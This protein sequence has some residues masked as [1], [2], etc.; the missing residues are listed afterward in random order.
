[1][2]APSQLWDEIRAHF[3]QGNG[4]NPTYLKAQM[5]NRRLQASENVDTFVQD[6]ERRRRLL[7][8]NG[9]SMEDWELADLLLSNS[10]LVFPQLAMDH[11]LWLGEHHP[12]DL[13]LAA[14]VQRLGTAEQ[15]H[16]Q[17]RQQGSNTKGHWY[18]D[19]QCPVPMTPEQTAARA[20][21]ESI[22]K[23][24][25]TEKNV[26]S[27][28]GAALMQLLQTVVSKL[29]GRGHRHL[30]H[31]RPCYDKGNAK[32]DTFPVTMYRSKR[33]VSL[34]T[35]NSNMT[36]VVHLEATIVEGQQSSISHRH[37]P[38][39]GDATNHRD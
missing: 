35:S 26:R 32:S 14:A 8:D 38:V 31:R 12:R 25:R 27:F 36:A 24:R 10:L 11:T 30:H 16:Q 15:S 39:T 5:Y 34:W 1:M 28:A 13:S 6:M 22:E 4:V 37:E 33:S 3:E 21:R 2:D 20:K 7:L 29:M 19:P 9:G 23:K 17:L 18:G